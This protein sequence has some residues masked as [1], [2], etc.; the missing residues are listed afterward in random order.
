M[1]TNTFR[2][3]GWT[4]ADAAGL[5]ILPGLVRPDEG[6]PTNQGGQ[7][8]ITHA[9]RFTLQNAVILNQFIYPG[10]HVANPGN[11]NPAVQP[12]MGARFRLKPGV[13]ISGLNPQSRI[14][15]QAMKDYGLILADNGSNFFFS[16]ASGAVDG[17][18][19]M[20]S[21]SRM[22]PAR[23]MISGSNW[24]INGSAASSPQDS[25]NLLRLPAMAGQG[26]DEPVAVANVV[27]RCKAT[28]ISPGDRQLEIPD[29]R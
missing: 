29:F 24:S 17:I 25:K 14:I 10:S 4:S 15:A 13:D 2:T 12:P 9:I 19:G 21:S 26:L 3:I 23:L 16:G 22:A 11:T 1:K 5:A 28:T 20:P 8:A 6:L 7:G 27:G 18:K